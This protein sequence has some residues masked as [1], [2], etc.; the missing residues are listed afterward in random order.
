M[1]RETSIQ[2]GRTTAGVER[3][4]IDASGNLG[5]GVSNPLYKVDVAGDLN[6]TGNFRVNGTACNVVAEPSARLA[7]VL[8][9]M[10]GLTGTKSREFT[11]SFLT[12][13]S[14]TLRPNA[15]SSS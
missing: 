12:A 9:D 14:Q 10:L 7:D 1:R 6:I 8:R 4:R 15:E 5:V 11:P 13:T 3:A 2:S